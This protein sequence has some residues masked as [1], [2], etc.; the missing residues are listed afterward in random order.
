MTKS[1][2]YDDMQVAIL[3]LQSNEG[4]EGGEREACARV[5]RWLETKAQAAY[6]VAAARNAGVSVTKLR[7]RLRRA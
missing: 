5:A 2:T 3:W 1:P 7:Q 4:E 6:E